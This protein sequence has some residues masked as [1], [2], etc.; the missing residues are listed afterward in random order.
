[1][2]GIEGTIENLFIINHESVNGPSLSFISILKVVCTN[3]SITSNSL[4]N[5]VNGGKIGVFW[6][7]YVSL[8]NFYVDSITGKGLFDIQFKSQINFENVYFRNSVCEGIGKGCIFFLD[9]NSILQLNYLDVFNI[10]TFNS[11]IYI[12]NSQ[13]I[14][15]QVKMDDI[16][17]DPRSTDQYIMMIDSSTSKIEY[18]YILHLNS[19]FCYLGAAHI[20]MENSYFGFTNEKLL[21]IGYIFFYQTFSASL[22]NVT[23]QNLG[24]FDYGVLI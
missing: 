8:A 1:M 11:L 18:F 2:E 10:S 19:R 7:S 22:Y 12:E 4:S 14:M 5:Y 17:M 21:S 24:T 16:Y 20:I 13:A 3:V 23:F 9:S 6:R 15:S